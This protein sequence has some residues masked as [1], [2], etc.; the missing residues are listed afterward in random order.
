MRS[1]GP[2]DVEA[3]TVLVVMV[4]EKFGGRGLSKGGPWASTATSPEDSPET[5]ALAPRPRHTE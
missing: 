3:D 2:S 1:R 4:A 5:Q